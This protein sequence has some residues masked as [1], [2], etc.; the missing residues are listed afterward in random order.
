MIAGALTLPLDVIKTRQQMMLGSDLK[1]KITIRQISK[2]IFDE[3]GLKGFTKG[4][5][6]R[7]MKV[8]PACAIMMT[9]YEATKAYYLEQKI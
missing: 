9:S 6:P 2:I 1:S 7:L 8:T 4:F 5:S 3:S